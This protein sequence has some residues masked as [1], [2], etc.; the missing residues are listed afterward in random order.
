[1]PSCRAICGV[2][3]PVLLRSC[4]F[5]HPINPSPANFLYCCLLCAHRTQSMATTIK[6]NRSAPIADRFHGAWSTSISAPTTRAR[7][8]TA[9]ICRT[10]VWAMSDNVLVA[11]GWRLADHKNSQGLSRIVELAGSN[12]TREFFCAQ[13]TGCCQSSTAVNVSTALRAAKT[14]HYIAR[15]LAHRHPSDGSYRH[16]AIPRLWGL[17]ATLPY[18]EIVDAIKHSCR[19]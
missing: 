12:P 10:L 15:S 19:Y 7:R 9:R 13:A 4:V 14:Q 5:I 2:P 3:K 8:L 11:H 6:L 16:P 17:A 18:P 1:M